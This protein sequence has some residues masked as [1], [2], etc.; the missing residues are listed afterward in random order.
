MSEEEKPERDKALCSRCDKV[1]TQ[2]Y[3]AYDAEQPPLLY[4]EEHLMEAKQIIQLSYV[5]YL[6]MAGYD[7]I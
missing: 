5:P 7:Q 1:G 2:W 4:C 3:P 6:K